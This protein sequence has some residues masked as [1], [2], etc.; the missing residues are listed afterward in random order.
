MP[1]P[2]V[3]MHFSRRSQLISISGLT[4]ALSKSGQDDIMS[5]SLTA[6]WGCARGTHVQGLSNGALAAIQSPEQLRLLIY[7]CWHT[8]KREAYTQLTGLII[9][10]VYI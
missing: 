2:P 1:G 4:Q 6:Q 5:P 10:S 3:C 8:I 9:H 7:K